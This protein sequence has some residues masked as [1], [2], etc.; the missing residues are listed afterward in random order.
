MRRREA[1][2]TEGIISETELVK[3]FATEKQSQKYKASKNKF[4]SSNKNTVL[5]Q[6]ARLCEIEDLG[7]RQYQISKIYEYP[8]PKNFDKMNAGLHKY[9]TPLI[10]INLIAAGIY[11]V[12]NL[13]FTCNK[14]YRMVDLIND[15]YVGMKRNVEYS[16]EKFEISKDALYDFFG[17]TDDTLVYYFKKS[18]EYL[19]EANLFNFQEINWVYVR[20]VNVKHNKDDK[21][22]ISI[23][24][25]HR[26]ATAS[27]MVYI[28]KCEQIACEHAGIRSDDESAK[29]YGKHSRAYLE[30]LRDLLIEQNIRFCYKAYEIYST[31]YD[32]QRCF[33]LLGAFEV[34]DK[35]DLIDMVNALFRRNL[36]VNAE[37]RVVNNPAKRNLFSSKDVERFLEDYNKIIGLTLN[38]KVDTL[39]LP[40]VADKGDEEDINMIIK[41]NVSVFHN[42][43]EMEI[44]VGRHS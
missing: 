29:Y 22:Y 16:S 13:T 36:M 26:R 20:A 9:L 41:K 17:T 10:L 44:G 5:K 12:K 30:K 33:Q 18:L 4:A 39:A 19:K 15:N 32:I 8:V 6:A 11:E 27:E 43:K 23:E 40:H 37:N 38:P 2:L 24:P 25:E 14:W 7:N 21:Q 34:S 1:K 28:R 3:L 35:A 42:G 31:D